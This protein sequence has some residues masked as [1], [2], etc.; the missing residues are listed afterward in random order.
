MPTPLKSFRIPKHLSEALRQ[1]AQARQDSESSVIRLALSKHLS[2][3]NPRP[4][5]TRQESRG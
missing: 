5:P 3:T 4:R 1:E 2:A